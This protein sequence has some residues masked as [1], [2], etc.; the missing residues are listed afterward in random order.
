[1][2][3]YTVNTADTTATLTIYLP[4]SSNVTAYTTS[5]SPGWG[6]PATTKAYVTSKYG[7]NHKAINIILTAGP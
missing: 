2:F 5:A 6:V 4:P 7:T 3:A 1:V